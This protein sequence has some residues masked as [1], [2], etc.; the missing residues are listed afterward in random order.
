MNEE[1]RIANALYSAELRRQLSCGARR[2]DFTRDATR[3]IF[4]RANRKFRTTGTVAEILTAPLFEAAGTL[5]LRDVHEIVQDQFT[6]VPRVDAD[7]Q[8]VSKANAARVFGNDADASRCF[9]QLRIFRQRNAI[10]HQHANTI[11]ILHAGKARI[12]AVP[13]AQWITVRQDE[14]LLLFRPLAGKWKQGLELLLIN[15]GRR[16]FVIG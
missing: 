15:H 8:G 1:I 14:F 2:A 13:R 4:Q 3:F 9:R 6:I 5:A 12:S 7:N 16:E 10:D 11:A